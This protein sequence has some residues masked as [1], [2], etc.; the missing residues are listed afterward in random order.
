VREE[1]E[2]HTG[3]TLSSLEGSV[4]E[5]VFGK[6][7]GHGSNTMRLL[8]LANSNS[9]PIFHVTAA[10]LASVRGRLQHSSD[11]MGDIDNAVSVGLEVVIPQFVQTNGTCSGSGCMATRN[12]VD[13]HC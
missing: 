2:M 1:R 10:N 4:I 6:R 13:V 11:V 5:Q 8:E 3:M 12:T 7:I 9:V